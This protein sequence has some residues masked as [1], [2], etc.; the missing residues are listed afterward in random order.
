MTKACCY[1][2]AG[3]FLQLYDD[4]KPKFDPTLLT[5]PVKPVLANL[6]DP[7]EEEQEKRVRSRQRHN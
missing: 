4:V 7:D 2:Q 5:R 6:P 3:L 1:C